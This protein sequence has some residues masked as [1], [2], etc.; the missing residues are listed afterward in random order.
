MW[1]AVRYRRERITPQRA[2]TV[3]TRIGHRLRYLDG[4]SLDVTP[5]H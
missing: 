2:Y 4:L 1:F 5:A 3:R